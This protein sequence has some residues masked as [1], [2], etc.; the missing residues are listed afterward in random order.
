MTKTA[1]EIQH[2]SSFHNFVS[3][4]TMSAQS[5]VLVALTSAFSDAAITRIWVL[6]TCWMLL[7]VPNQ[8]CQSIRPVLV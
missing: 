5:C 7:L 8:Q 6:S 3:L 2:L 4:M 1:P